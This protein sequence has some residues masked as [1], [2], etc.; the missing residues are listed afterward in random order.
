MQ[1]F[2]ILKLLICPNLNT[3]SYLGGF[4]IITYHYVGQLFYYFIF[5]ILGVNMSYFSGLIFGATTT[6]APLLIF[7]PFTGQGIMASNT[8]N[9]LKTSFMFF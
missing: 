1:L 3:K 8:E 4:S 7:M 5:I 6:F 2:I 9:P